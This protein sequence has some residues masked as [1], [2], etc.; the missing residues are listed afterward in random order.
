[1]NC[2]CILISSILL[3][4]TGFAVSLFSTANAQSADDEVFLH[5]RHQSVVNTYVSAV[6]YNDQF[7]L[8]INETFTALG[9]DHDI[10]SGTLAITGNYLGRG[11]YTIDLNNQRA[12]FGEI[13]RTFSAEKFLITDFGYYL[14][15][16]LLYNLFGLDFNVSLRDLS[17][18]LTT[19]DT[20]PVVAQRERERQRERILRTQRE[21][22][23]EF[24]PLRQGRETHIFNAGFL[25]YN[26]TGNFS[27]TGNSFLFNTQI[28]TE[29]A[30]G[31]LQ[32]TIFGNYTETSSSLRS[33][34]LRWRYGI[35]DNDYISTVQA[36]QNNMRG[37]APANYTGIRVTNEPIE[38]RF[39]YGETAFTGSATPGSE[40]E[41]YRNNSLVDFTE[42]DESGQYR[43]MVPITYGTSQYSIRTF[44]PTGEESRRDT[45]LQIPFNFLPP[46]EVTYTADA[47]RLDNPIS[48]STERGMVA[49]TRVN[50][51]LTDRITATGGVE[52]FEDFH[53]GLPTF[54]GR[55][56]GR[57][58]TNHLVAIEAANEAFYRGTL[59]AI[60]GNGASVNVD[61]TYFN[62]MGGVYN[63]SGNQ[64][65][66]RTNLFTPFQIGSFPLFFRWSFSTEQRATSTVARYRVDLNTRVGR[67]NFRF[68]YRDSQLG[69]LEFTTTPTARM[70]ASA[71]YNFGRGRDVPQFVRGV[72]ARA[73]LNYVPSLNEIEDA[74]VQVSRSIMRSG[75]LQASAGRNFIGDFNLFRFTL[76]FD[77]TN[78]R[79]NTSVRSSRNVTTASQ[80]VRGSVGYDSNHNRV[81]LTNRQQVGRA[82]VAVRMFVDNNNSGTYDEGDELIHESAARV[83]RAGGA[84]FTRDGITYI[85]QLQPYRQYN[86]TI[87]KASLNNPMLVPLVENF[88]I[89]TDPNQF[90]L[91]E[92]PFYMSGIIDGMVYRVADDG[93]RTG[94]GGLRL[95]LTQIDPPEGSSPHSEEL[96]T[97]SDGSFYA[98]EIPPGKYQLEA[99]PSQLGFLN[100][101][102]VP[103]V[104]EFT[105]EAS[106][107]GDFVEGLEI[108]I[109]PEDYEPVLPELPIAASI[110]TNEVYTFG[111]SNR[112]QCEFRIELASFSSFASAILFADQVETEMDLQVEIEFDSRSGLNVLRTSG[113]YNYED[114]RELA[115]QLLSSYAQAIAVINLCDD[116][117]EAFHIQL[118][119][120]SIEED[121]ENYLDYIRSE[122]PDIARPLQILRTKESFNTLSGQFLTIADLDNAVHSILYRSGDLLA[123]LPD[124]EGTPVEETI[125]DAGEI[126]IPDPVR[127]TPPVVTPPTPPLT[128][129]TPPDQ[130]TGETADTVTTQ[131]LT[132]IT[133]PDVTPSPPITVPPVLADISGM[134]RY[135][136]EEQCFYSVQTGSFRN[137][138]NALEAAEV[139]YEVTGIPFDIYLNSM[140]NLYAVRSSQSL[141][142]EDLEES[143][144]SIRDRLGIDAVA[145]LSRC[146]DGA[147]QDGIDL[148]APGYNIQIGAFAIEQNASR[149]MEHVRERYELPVFSAY[150]PQLD[151]TR[152]YIGTIYTV[153]ELRAARTVIIDELGVPDYIIGPAEI[154]NHKSPAFQY[155]LLLGSFTE[156]E[157]LLR[158]V[159][160]FTERYDLSFYIIQHNDTR[161]E[162]ITDPLQLPWDAV[163]ELKNE[164]EQ[165]GELGNPYLQL[166]QTVERT[167]PPVTEAIPDET[168]DSEQTTISPED[169]LPVQGAEFSLANCTFPIQ[170]GSYGGHTLAQEMADSFTEIYQTD[171]GLYY[172]DRTDMFAL[173]T[174]AYSSISHAMQRL[175]DFKEIDGFNE[176]AIVGQCG[177][178]E[179]VT[180]SVPIRYLIPVIRYSSIEMAENYAE[181]NLRPANISYVIRQ[182]Q[183]GLYAVFAGPYNRYV[184][185]MDSRSDLTQNGILSDPRVV[186]D[187]Q[188]RNRL[189]SQFQ[190]YYG[191]YSDALT[192]EILSQSGRFIIVKSDPADELHLFDEEIYGS[193]QEFKDTLNTVF[194]ISG[195]EINEIFILD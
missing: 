42:T 122:I 41:L 161:Y 71:T 142:Y 126:D 117:P 88:S 17:L 31:D 87:N 152:V 72:F 121:A 176:Y 70:N 97:F 106:A 51:G 168:D 12:T 159:D 6:Y 129:I 23:R 32:G 75:R 59:S 118:G 115:G 103:E 109:Y 69:R 68:G 130:T 30:G 153:D 107:Q 74:E 151:V 37:L 105:V 154:Q 40:V 195:S 131:P 100:A 149:Y 193:W 189:T 123:D 170:L 38:P 108:E 112:M 164:I 10:D 43:F 9:I 171:I 99:D 163:I 91:I 54:I 57:L 145:V 47:G 49:Q 60:Y 93:R 147:A 140:N 3:L 184:T 26:L 90:K 48:G 16:E 114:T 157:D 8:S 58:M 13:R 18:S 134:I 102:S 1:M 33:S 67:A 150:N 83:D 167:G 77:F 162:L 25:D 138:G 80:S 104:L 191:P 95:Y 56:S 110:L 173:R 125:S 116:M 141:A 181:T 52:Y 113:T 61:Y 143:T 85:S 187:P 192:D 174:E 94:T 156:P 5:F 172:N 28:G 183:E 179:Y 27:E 92:I 148:D 36:G 101:I 65:M 24:Y 76:T 45:R 124:T 46:G 133:P 64:S 96:R 55:L 22:R 137:F 89:I 169:L 39:L 63:P 166:R 190:I 158:F 19:E 81:L 50:A 84:R 29:L 35:R 7:Y 78:V 155:K 127:I 98:Y 135:Q 111:N 21:L 86:M 136:Y 194:E 182:D 2:R 144:R 14:D 79:S 120:F 15:P 146:V 20:M 82:G 132:T 53:D 34:G 188:S 178:D 185:A 186:I 165:D 66:L 119:A 177:E 160:L 11:R 175:I 73:Q 4:L 139:S 128:T 62:T 44:S 180:D